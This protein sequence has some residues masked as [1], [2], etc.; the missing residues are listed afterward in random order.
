MIDS[1]EIR[2]IDLLAIKHLNELAEKGLISIPNE[3]QYKKNY[4]TNYSILKSNPGILPTLSFN[5]C[6]FH[7]HEGNLGEKY[8]I[9]TLKAPLLYLEGKSVEHNKSAQRH[10]QIRKFLNRPQSRKIN[11][12]VGIINN[13]REIFVPEHDFTEENGF[14]INHASNTAIFEGNSLFLNIYRN[15]LNGPAAWLLTG[16]LLQYLEDA[17]NKRLQQRMNEYINKRR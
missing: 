15:R 8:F 16:D 14:V 6:A 3:I 13:V 10:E 12:K 1:V 7:L 9:L 4:I 11:D 17:R 2:I 5:F